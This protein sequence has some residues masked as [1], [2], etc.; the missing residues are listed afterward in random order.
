MKRLVYLLIVVTSIPIFAQQMVSTDAPS[1]HAYGTNLSLLNS[2]GVGTFVSGYRQVPSWSSSLTLSSTYRFAHS[3]YN[4]DL[5]LS[6]NAG[7]NGSWLSSYFT[8]IQ[9]VNNRFLWNDVFVT[10]SAPNWFDWLDVGISLSPNISLTGPLS[11]SSQAL[12]RLGGLG[13]GA[14]LA[15]NRSDFSLSW[16]PSFTGWLHQGASISVPCSDFAAPPGAGIDVYMQGFTG[17]R[18]E[19]ID[20][21]SCKLMGRQTLGMLSNSLNF[22]WAPGRHSLNASLG[23]FLNFLRPLENHPDL[24]ITNASHQGFVEATMGRFAYAYRVPV[25]FNLVLSAGVISFQ[26]AFDKQGNIIFPFFDF[27][28]PGKNQTQLFFQ[29]TAGI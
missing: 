22:G 16:S 29:V 15:F 11:K 9:A 4:P 17:F 5:L 18:E 1:I 27:V 13:L 25:D 6:A 14:N 8:S 20:G 24:T 10:L 26:A 3:T 28:T 23:W 21:N 7:L 12:G 2:L 19:E